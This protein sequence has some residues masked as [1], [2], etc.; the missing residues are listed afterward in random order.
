MYKTV[1]S[2]STTKGIIS[3][4]AIPAPE[5]DCMPRPANSSSASVSVIWNK[6]LMSMH[7]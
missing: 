1:Q 2:A 6:I 5:S 3:S 7:I 4:Y